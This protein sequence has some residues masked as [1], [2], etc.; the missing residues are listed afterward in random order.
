MSLLTSFNSVVS[1]ASQRVRDFWNRDVQFPLLS[2]TSNGALVPPMLVPTLAA[3]NFTTNKAEAARQKAILKAR[4]FHRG[5]H[6]VKLT[7][8]LVEFLGSDPEDAPCL[9]FTHT[10]TMAVAERLSVIGF[11]TEGGTPA[12]NARQQKWAETV[13]AGSRMKVKQ[14]DVHEE[15]LVDAEHLILIEWNPDGAG[16]RGE[17]EWT[18]HPRYTDANMMVDSEA[19]NGFGMMMVYP[20]HDTSRR[21]LYAL[22]RSTEI[23]DEGKPEARLT[24]YRRDQIEK[25]FRGATGW[26]PL[27]EILPDGTEK[28]W[29]EA[30]VDPLTKR[31]LGIPVVHLKTPGLRSE[32]REAQRNQRALNKLYLDFLTANDETAFR[33]WLYFGWD[34]SGMQSAPGFWMGSPKANK[35]EAHAEAVA[36]ADTTPMLN[37]IK[38]VIGFIAMVTDTPVS[39]LNMSGQIA[40]AE[41][42]QAQDEP[43]KAKVENRQSGFGMA[44]EDTFKISR[45]LQNVF[46][47][48]VEPDGTA[49]GRMSEDV[50]IRP[51]WKPFREPIA[52][53]VTHPAATPV[54]PV[55][56]S[57]N[58]AQ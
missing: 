48:P 51:I 10:T 50:V 16:G 24:I 54:A 23:N 26:M 19:G 45:R 58:P 3:T 6:G 53:P 33:T 52:A 18:P 47:S 12:E 35:T 30:W 9:N 29:P 5:D 40:R 1:R 25:Y 41:T 38:D 55:A 37:G 27:R 4:A 13:W 14:S 43:L 56:A 32:A 2:D 49:L 57:T 31:P 15:A 34:P 20:N 42:L 8:R 39:R 21:P 28:A 11:E 46:G 22:K 44:Y 7:K 36:G 17:V